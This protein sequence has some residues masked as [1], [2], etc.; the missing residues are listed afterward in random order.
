MLAN[1]LIG[2]GLVLVFAGVYLKWRPL[3]SA[4]MAN[5]VQATVDQGSPTPS[6]AAEDKG[7]EFEKWVV[8]RLSKEYHK[9]RDWRSDKRSNNGTYAASSM[10][11]D[12][13]VVLNLHGTFYPFAMECKWRQTTGGALELNPEQLAR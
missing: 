7:Y 10:N 3:G 4:A 1:V 11:P 9:T 13:E 6:M 8:D 12:V 2:L 5:V